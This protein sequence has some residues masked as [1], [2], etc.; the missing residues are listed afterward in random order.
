[1]AVCFIIEPPDV[2]TA[3]YE[4]V[5]AEVRMDVDPP[6]GLVLHC[7]G[8]AGDGTW[9]VVEVWDSSAAQ[10]TFLRERL[11]PALQK[12]GVRPPRITEVSLHDLKI[13]RAA[14]V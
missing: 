9:R 13:A 7:A 6:D 3:V 1:M 4:R 2:D 5:R 12:V 14:A 11:G 10:Q 8:A